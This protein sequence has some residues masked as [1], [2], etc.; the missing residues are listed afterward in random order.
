MLE[1]SYVIASKG[2]SA[3]LL[4]L[5]T[6]RRR[7]KAEMALLKEEEEFKGEARASKDSRIKEL[8][9]MLDAAYK[10]SKSNAA[11]A[12]ILTDMISKG[13]V[14]QNTD[15]TVSALAALEEDPVSKFECG[16]DF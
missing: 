8:E 14:K 9:G 5:G 1:H 16:S 13:H 6:K 15:G 7:T 12:D 11:A 2:I 3:N 4:K 10:E